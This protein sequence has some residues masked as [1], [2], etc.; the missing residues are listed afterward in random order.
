LTAR[1]TP[2]RRTTLPASMAPSNPG[3][4]AGHS[5]ET[6]E[7]VTTLYNIWTHEALPILPGESVKDRF[8]EFLRDH[9]TNQPTHMD[10][11][12]VE[13]LTSV[14]NKFSAKRIEIVSGYRSPKY[15]LM[16]RKKG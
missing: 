14:A 8:H 6:L 10:P 4:N 15:N 2:A 9:F 7:P 5:G 16:L 13:V 12:L 3:I 1:K 11:K